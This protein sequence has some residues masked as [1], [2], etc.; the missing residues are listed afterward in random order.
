VVGVSS[1]NNNGATGTLLG[2]VSIPLEAFT[3]T[4]TG[5]SV[6]QA[7]GTSIFEYGAATL[8]TGGAGTLTLTNSGNNF[9]GLTLTTGGG[10]AKITETGT[11]NYTSVSTAGGAL[12][13]VSNTNIVEGAATGG[14][15]SGAGTTFTTSTGSINL[16]NPNN[17]FGNTAVQIIASGNAAFTDINATGTI[18]ADQTNVTGNLTV[19]NPT[20]GAYIKDAG[21]SSTITVGGT[22]AALGKTSGAGYVLFVGA[23]STFGAVEI[24]AGTGGAITSSLLDNGPLALAPGSSVAGPL[25]LTS[26]GNITTI[27][28][29]G[30]TFNG[31]LQLVAS[32]SIVISNPLYITGVL[33]TDAIAGPTNLSFLSKVANLNN[34]TPVNLGNTTNYVGP[35]P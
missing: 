23:A 26:A 5:G 10:A 35:S 22:F 20:S 6:T 29:G 8:T 9:G 14:I 1:L 31:T 34:Q 30:S 7:T 33:T 11:S 4:S 17:N 28:T 18:L 13:A 3:V 27:G 24:Q 21:S 15:Q 25:A 2:N 19:T 16:T 12:V 32:G